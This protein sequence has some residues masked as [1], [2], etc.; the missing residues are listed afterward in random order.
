MN[1][2]MY[3][4]SSS[5]HVRS[6]LTSA[7]VMYDVLLALLPAAGF[8][9]YR[10]G[11]HAFLVIAVSI[12]SAVLTEFV[13]DWI[14]KKPNTV[15]DGSAAVTGLL[16]A[17]CLPAGVPLYVPCAGSLFAILFVKCFFGGLGHNFM[18]PALAGRCFLLLSFSGVMVNYAVDGVS[19]A[20]PLEVL[21]AG[22]AVSAAE[23]F[24]GFGGGVIG[25]SIAALCLGGFYLFTIRAIT[26]EIPAAMLLSFTAFIALFGGR[27]FDPAFIGLHLATGG[28]VMGALFMA[29]DPV[30]SPVTSA[31]QM[32]YGVLTG[33]LCG[34]FRIFG[35]V[36]DSVSYAIIISNMA[37][38]LIDEISIPK[39][40]GFREQADGKKGIPKSA[41]ILCAITLIAG[42]ALSGV[43][44]MT[45]AR[46]AEQ[47][48]AA[49]AASYRE[50][51]PGAVDFARDD[52]LNEAVE[53]LGG[54]SYGTDF[55]KA[56]INEV[57][58]GTDAGGQTAGYVISVTSADGFAGNI[59]LSVGLSADG[60]VTGISFTELNETAG[61]GMLCGEDA[62]KSQ[63]AGVRTERFR[64]NKAGGSTADDEI[65]SIS[66][67]S[68]SSGAVV[69]AVNAALDFYAQHIK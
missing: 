58:V 46:I 37:A 44:E 65:D 2:K 30:T 64:L 38:P 22:E 63:F 57:I 61:L 66:G 19:S 20:T 13:F 26:F 21:A 1:H 14:V 49:K 36:P 24:L 60:T 28:V 54:E 9:V 6:R 35:S 31:G 42:A 69:N 12:L 59:T 16:L 15:K 39:P 17:L 18:N 23:A 29:T 45:K 25:C 27:G 10:Y 33:V 5:P 40:Y 51:C 41:L 4:V 67:A 50:V 52:A 11:F 34:I 32:M 7:G 68:I 62:F 55:G 43:Y 3:N 8:G 56:Y 47:E 48:L 53:S